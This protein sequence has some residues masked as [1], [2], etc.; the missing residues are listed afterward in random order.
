MN[1]CAVV[2]NLI[3]HLHPVFLALQ[4]DDQQVTL[5]VKIRGE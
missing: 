4:I 2:M 5:V 1:A 3:M